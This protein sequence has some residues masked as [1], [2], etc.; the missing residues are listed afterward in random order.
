[1]TIR[2]VFRKASRERR[3]VAVMLFA[4]LMPVLIAFIALSVDTA[5]IAAARSQLSTAADAAA[6]AGAQQMA[7]EYRVRGVT[8]MS[9]QITA[10]QNSAVAFGA[11]NKVFNQSVSLVAGTNGS[12]SSDIQ[13]GYLDP[14]NTH[15]SL[16]TT[17]AL[18][19]LFNS[20]QSRI[21]SLIWP[22]WSPFRIKA[23]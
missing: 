21:S 2:S 10:A 23:G 7:T 16:I 14:N 19:P 5:M 9:S 13:V 22:C 12:S 11:N 15:S 8:D 1:M 20:V 3:G 18:S 17:S 6:L 4:L